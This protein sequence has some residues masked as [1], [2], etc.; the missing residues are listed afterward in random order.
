MESESKARF[1]HDFTATDSEGR[2][3]QLSD[4]KGKKHV[5]LVFNRGFT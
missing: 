3:V 5:V 4:F 2:A 1:A